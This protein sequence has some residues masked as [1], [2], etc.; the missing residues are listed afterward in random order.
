MKTKLLMLIGVFGFALTAYPCSSN[1]N[2]SIGAKCIKEAGSLYGVCVGGYQSGA[3]KDTGFK[4]RSDKAGNSCTSTYQCGI[5]GKCLKEGN[6][7]RGT[8][9]K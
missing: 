3:P 6:S 8:C 7:Y 1:L 2:C 4:P 5:G 9:T